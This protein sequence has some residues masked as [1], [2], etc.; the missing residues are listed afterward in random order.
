M[1]TVTSVSIEN[2]GKGYVNGITHVTLNLEHGS[3]NILTNLFV[4]ITVNTSG[5]VIT[6]VP[7]DGKTGL[8]FLLNDLVFIDPVATTIDLCILRITGI[9]GP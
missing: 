6:A 3:T 2:P 5:E 4:E 7:V 8:G 9:Q 1:S